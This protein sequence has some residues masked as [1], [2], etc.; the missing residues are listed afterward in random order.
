MA[1]TVSKARSAITG[2][3]ISMKEAIK[4]PKTTVVEKVKVGPVKKQR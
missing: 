3:F 2:R 1:R 4:Q